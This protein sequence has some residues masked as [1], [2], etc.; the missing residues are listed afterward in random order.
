MPSSLQ[1]DLHRSVD[2]KLD[3]EAPSRLVAHI[4]GHTTYA[5]TFIIATLIEDAVVEVGR[6]GHREVG[7]GA[8]DE[9]NRLAI[10]LLRVERLCL[11]NRIFTSSCT[12][13]RTDARITLSA[14]RQ[15]SQRQHQTYR[16]R[17]SHLFTLLLI[18]IRAPGLQ[19]LKEVVTLI[20]NKD[21]GGEVFHINLPHG[22]HTKFRILDALDALDARLRE[23]GS[24]ATDAAQKGWHR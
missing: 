3:I 15:D 12:F 13:G 17:S 9:Y 24:H 7:I 6:I 22:L 10:G 21:K 20:I 19:R 18:R 14:G 2:I 11:R 23:N 5:N 4:V 16:K 8:R 1:I